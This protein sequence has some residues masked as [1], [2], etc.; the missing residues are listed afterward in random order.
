MWRYYE[1]RECERKRLFQG[2]MRILF[3]LPTPG[4]YP[5]Q[6]GCVPAGQVKKLGSA[7]KEYDGR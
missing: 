7:C 4:F 1:S 5:S 3:G 2:T 6:V